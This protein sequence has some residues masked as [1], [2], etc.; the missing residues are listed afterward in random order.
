M[1]NKVY[2]Q[3]KAEW[4]KNSAFHA[5]DRKHPYRVWY[6]KK[7]LLGWNLDLTGKNILEIGCGGG[8]L[9][10]L[11]K[12]KDNKVWGVDFSEEMV[13]VATKNNPGIIF[14]TAGA[15]KLL[16]NSKQFDIVVGVMLFHHLEAQG[17][18]GQ[19]FLEIARV[20]KKDGVLCVL[21]HSGNLI[22]K[23]M[24]AFLNFCRSLF[25]LFKKNFAASGS[26]SEMMI[27]IAEILSENNWAIV[28]EKPFQTIFY[29]ILTTISH[30]LEYLGGERRAIGFEKATLPILVFIEENLLFSFWCTEEIIVARKK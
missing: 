9:T 15:E 17:L 3:E 23:L 13:K 7:V 6:W 26:S 16:F 18:T 20:L 2:K 29:Q 19:S 8:Y 24:L 10:G 11:L 21:D 12:N 1:K 27:N 5:D 22:S 4:D 14:E 28:S 30:M 25:L